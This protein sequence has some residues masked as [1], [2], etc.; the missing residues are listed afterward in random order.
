MTIGIRYAARSDVGM[1]REGNEDSAYAGSR[2]I[3]VADGMG[4][5]VGGEIASAAAINTL[6]RLDTDVPAPELLA[7]LEHA[8]KEANEKLHEI[9]EG[10]PSLQG[11]GTTLTA[12]LWSG[13]HIA[14]VHIGDSRGY[15]LRNGELFQIT[16]DHTLVQ[17]LVDEGRIS[18]DE[19]ASHPQRSLLLR[20]LDGRGEVD[21]DLALREAQVGD[22]YLL[23]SDGLSGVVSAETIHEVLSRQADPEQ[24]VR[25][26][27]DLANRG[28]GPD[29]ITCVVADVI[30]LSA[31][32]PVIRPVLAGAA[33]TSA[34]GAAA[35]Q[36]AGDTPAQR[37]AEFHDTLPQPAVGIDGMPPAGPP[38]G[39]PGAAQM[40]GRAAQAPPPGPPPRE[41]LGGHQQQRSRGRWTF[42]IVAV[43]IF[44]IVVGGAGYFG[45]NAVT[46]GYY[47]GAENGKVVL[48]QG[49]P[50][51]VLG[52]NKN[53]K[54]N[55]KGLQDIAVQ[56]LSTSAGQRVSRHDKLADTL[57]AAVTAANGLTRCTYSIKPNEGGVLAI[58]RGGGSDCQQT[59]TPSSKNTKVAELPVKDRADFT[60]AKAATGMAGLTSLAAAQKALATLDSKAAT[61]KTGNPP[62]ECKEGSAQ[63]SANAGTGTP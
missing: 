8:V 16:H 50:A 53:N 24:A 38:P 37:A 13:S 48:Y 54:A 56:D 9:V 26:L 2:L 45:Y 51:G 46:S 23:C 39:G 58:F 7:A 10:D 34:P 61:C 19:A 11:M 22:R 43:V 29:N 41:P 62:A 15:L 60:G 3:A 42:L 28:G 14:L 21:P 30:D 36:R 31:Q 18:L 25:Q 1:L 33:A 12:M 5:H 35:P 6:R 32:P 57:S 47:V 4:G 40:P 27:I 17:S 59:V 20:A 63:K 44:L 52:F 55:A 49:D